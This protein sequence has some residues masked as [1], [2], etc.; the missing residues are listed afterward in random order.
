M[1]STRLMTHVRNAVSILR[2]RLEGLDFIA[3][4]S[5]RGL[6]QS[7]RDCRQRDG[8]AP[9]RRAWWLHAQYERYATLR[10]YAFLLDW[11]LAEPGYRATR[12]PLPPHA[13]L[14]VFRFGHLGDVLHLLPTIEEIQRQRPDV[15][16]ELVT[17]PW[18]KAL[19]SQL[20]A[21]R[22]VHF[23]T[24]DVVQF[25]R[26]S[27]SGVRRPQDERTWIR[28]TRGDGVDAVFCPAVPHFSELPL[29]VGMQAA[30]YIGSEWPL[31]VPV[32][33]RRH[34]FPFDSRRYEA[35][36]VADFLPLMGLERAPVR[37][38]YR[39]PEASAARVGALLRERGLEK[40]AFI[41]AF[42][43]SGWPGKCWP[44]DRFA[45]ALEAC[46]SEA[47]VA[48]VLGGSPNEHDLCES[49]RT[50]MAHSALNLAGLLSL[51]E[52]AALIERAAVVLCNDSATLHIAAALGRP[53][54]SLWGPTFQEK[55]APRGSMHH[56]I[57]R[58]GECAGCTYWHP[59]ARCTGMPPC[60]TTIEKRRVADALLNAIR[61]GMAESEVPL[62]S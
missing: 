61:C 36:S 18:N 57:S 26:G 50:G 49:V 55:W 25:H 14:I 32:S 8:L 58:S 51:D 56:A 46:S 3:N 19:L 42:P 21:F 43:G 62:E 60:I 11:A 48:V 20:G 54:V 15:R 13:R 16:M 59:S 1:A 24:P 6:P 9:I 52:S 38:R 12:E 28:E 17:G 4:A 2:N 41:A 27:R 37:L 30:H 31:D 35:D 29:M 10:R 45:A 47:G 39:V 5:S 40:R 34:V 33:G 44:A 7:W 23:F 22:R 53:T